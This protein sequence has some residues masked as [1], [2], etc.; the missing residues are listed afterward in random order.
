VKTFLRSLVLRPSAY[1]DILRDERANGR[2]VLV[3]FAMCTIMG[4]H[5]YYMCT[6]GYWRPYI[7]YKIWEIVSKNVLIPF[8][9]G[10]TVCSVVWLVFGIICSA[11]ARSSGKP[12]GKGFVAAA[13]ALSPVSILLVVPIMLEYFNVTEIPYTGISLWKFVTL[14]MIIWLLLSE[15]V[16]IASMRLK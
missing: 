3:Y 15:L 10:F 9:G 7:R 1:R 14:V 16:A 4:Y 2:G 6:M 5:F 11:V 13:Y 12:A 8:L